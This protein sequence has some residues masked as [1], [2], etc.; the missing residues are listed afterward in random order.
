MSV[1]NCSYYPPETLDD[2]IPVEAIKN[3]NLQHLII[4]D[5][6]LFPEKK[7]LQKVKEILQSKNK[8]ASIS[9]K[10]EKFTDN[11]LVLSYSQNLDG[12]LSE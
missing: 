2:T 3:E 6:A 12:T 8:D 11:S 1:H 5:D 4:M 10:R 7:E 9:L